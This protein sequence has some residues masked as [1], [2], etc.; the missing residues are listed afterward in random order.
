MTGIYGWGILARP[1]EPTA[2]S[3]KVEVAGMQMEMVSEPEVMQGLNDL[4]RK[5][6]AAKLLVLSEYTFSDP[7]PEPILRWCRNH[8]RYLIIGGE[9][10]APKSNYYN[11]AFVIGPDGK[12]IFRQAK[13]VPI[14]FFKDGLPAPEQKLWDSPWGKIGLC[15]CYDLSYTRV[16]DRLVRLGAQAL[17]VPTMDVEDWGR[18]Q[19]EMHARVAPVRASEY[20][21]PIFRVAS[22]GISQLVDCSGRTVSSAGFAGHGEALDGI[23]TLG[24]SGSLPMDR[25]LAP[26][27][28]GVTVAVIVIVA[29][30]ERASHRQKPLPG[31]EPAEP[32]SAQPGHPIQSG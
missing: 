15:I 20:S 16:T 17:V 2:P 12:I 9:D 19:H 29:A 3:T 6:P 27:A 14:Q 26:I 1:A 5:H 13:C 8:Q 11:T 21:I 23:L 30:L 31:L 32:S 18:R 4:I 22:S 25:W 7:I 10:T 28:T 24:P